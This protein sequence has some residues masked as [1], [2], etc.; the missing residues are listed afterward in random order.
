MR[1]QRLS[2]DSSV[3]VT[4]T[5][6]SQVVSSSLHSD[7]NVRQ[8][9]T[10]LLIFLVIQWIS[11]II[12]FIIDS[13]LL[14]KDVDVNHRLGLRFLI[15]IALSFIYY[16]AGLVAV[17]LI[18]HLGIYVFTW[19]GFLQYVSLCFEV[20]LDLIVVVRHPSHDRENKV[21]V[22]IT[23]IIAMISLFQTILMVIT[24]KLTFH[25]LRLMKN[26]Q[27]DVLERI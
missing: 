20:L 27:R 19:L 2:E 18:H 3:I 24:M 9:R 8:T 15:P 7:R 21:N 12:L 11:S 23:L 22:T 6:E 10:L 13:Y 4:E 5:G 16:T 14:A 17:Y 1:Y 26:F 25:L